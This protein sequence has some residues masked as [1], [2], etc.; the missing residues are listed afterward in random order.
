MKTKT[1]SLSSIKLFL[2]MPLFAALVIVSSCGTKT[3]EVASPNPDQVYVNVDSLPVFTGGD[4]ALLQYIA[5]KTVYPENA[6]KNGVQ[7]KVIVKFIVEK[8]GSVTGTEV[9]KGVDPLLN[10]EAVRVVSTLPKFEK[11]GLNKGTI[12]RVYFTVPIQFSL[13]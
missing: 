1:N 10:A 12:V 11:P 6:I 4:A 3:N 13:K 7:G 5:E 2:I 9:V 8:D